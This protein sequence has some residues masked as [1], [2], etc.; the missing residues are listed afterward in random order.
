MA[1]SSLVRRMVWPGLAVIA[2]IFATGCTGF[3]SGQFLTPSSRLRF[4][5]ADDDFEKMVENDPFPRAE[6][7]GLK[8]PNSSE[9]R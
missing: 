9:P 2:L 1:M 3:F 5:A 8:T 4:F 6:Q 7:V